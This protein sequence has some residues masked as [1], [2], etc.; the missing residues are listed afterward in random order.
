MSTHRITPTE[1]PL[2]DPA[3]RG[4]TRGL[5]VLA[6]VLVGAAFAVSATAL[7]EVAAWA[8][9][10]EPLRWVMAVLVDAAVLVFIAAALHARHEG[11]RAGAAFSWTAVAVLTGLSATLNALHAAT[12][13]Y[14]GDR[15]VAGVAQAA[16]P[17]LLVWAGTHVLA[18]VYAATPAELARRRAAA[19]AAMVAAEQEQVDRAVRAA[20]DAEEAAE[21]EAQAAIAASRRAARVA[22]AQA[23]ADAEVAAA[24]AR[25]EADAAVA[26]E[27][28]AARV[29]GKRRP[30]DVAGPAPTAHA[31]V[32]A[33]APTTTAVVTAPAPRPAPVPAASTDDL[34][35]RARALAREG[36]SQRQI[37]EALGVGKTS[38]ARWLTAEATT[39]TESSAA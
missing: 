7:V 32:P 37:A 18:S 21:R 15:L 14:T 5:T 1:R 20:R 6:V 2:L 11:R 12:A 35:D 26:T 28:A 23:E 8:N 38:V 19:E 25:A 39:A 9:V 3:S 34:R 16:L 17:P 13:G 27:R 31:A 36:R 30:A 29:A 24:R 10:A 22:A 33:C 4:F